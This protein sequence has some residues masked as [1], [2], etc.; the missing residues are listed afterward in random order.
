[1]RPR[2]TIRRR[3]RRRAIGALMFAGQNVV[4]RFTGDVCGTGRCLVRL[5]SSPI[6]N[7]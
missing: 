4:A 7:L 2:A 3:S 5:L 1:M 6:W